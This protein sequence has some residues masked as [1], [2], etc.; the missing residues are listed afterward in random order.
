[1]NSFE[2]IGGENRLTKWVKLWDD[3]IVDAISE[4]SSN[5]RDQRETIDNGAYAK[6]IKRLLKNV[7]SVNGKPLDVKVYLSEE[8]NAFAYSNNVVRVYSGMMDCMKDNE[9]IAII[10]HE[11]G[12]IVHH[13][14][15]KKMRYKLAASIG[16][17]VLKAT[18][19]GKLLPEL[20]S[21]ITE[22]YLN[23]RYSRKAEEKA[24]DYGLDFAV[25]QGYSPSSMAD[26]LEVFV[27]LEEGEKSHL[28]ERMF[29]SHPDSKDRAE[30]L[31]ALGDVRI[32]QLN[33]DY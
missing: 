3:D 7:N 8:I 18:R 6:R 10:G 2:E 28:I 25:S 11:I 32:R 13:D 23:S 17:D 19:Y 5:E 31:R 15:R 14:T 16:R 21:E 20:V 26:A 27:K 33:G 9:L 12:H 29:S 1:M 30:R 22:Q 24:D 4:Q